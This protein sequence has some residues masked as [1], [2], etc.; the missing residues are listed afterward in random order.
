MFP[1][2][3]KGQSQG[4]R[5]GFCKD[6]VTCLFP[7]SCRVPC[8]WAGLAFSLPSGRGLGSITSQSPF[9]PGHTPL[10]L[11]AWVH[12]QECHIPH[13]SSVTPVQHFSPGLDRTHAWPSGKLV[14]SLII[15]PVSSGWQC[16]HRELC[17]PDQMAHEEPRAAHST[18]SLVAGFPGF[19]YHNSHWWREEG[20]ID[21]GVSTL[22]PPLARKTL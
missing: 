11:A 9:Q 14:T 6:S 19:R 18:V 12:P 15:Q 21:A 8:G 7:R 5:T 1:V 2:T 4:A 17:A 3:E 13:A 10:S 20:C 22:R 16:A